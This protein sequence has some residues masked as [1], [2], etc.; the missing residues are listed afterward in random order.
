MENITMTMTTRTSISPLC[1][2]D[3]GMPTPGYRTLGASVAPIPATGLSVLGQL[4][5]VIRDRKDLAAKGHVA[6]VADVPGI[7]AWSPPLC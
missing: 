4:D 1:P 7:H 6:F 3:F 5:V 2:S